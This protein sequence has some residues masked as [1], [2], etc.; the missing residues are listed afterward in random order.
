VLIAALTTGFVERVER[1]P[2]IPPEVREQVAEV[3]QKGIPVAPVADVEQAARDQGVPADEAQALAADY[4]DAQLD[5]L[6][7]AIGAVA[8]LAL[9]SLW[10]TRR[11]PGRAPPAA[12]SPASLAGGDTG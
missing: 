11:L 9:L 12:R 6:K 8:L 4:G 10:S 3:A 1:N 2:A 7:R 5:G